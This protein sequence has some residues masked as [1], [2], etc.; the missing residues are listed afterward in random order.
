MPFSG[1]VRL[2]AWLVCVVQLLGAVACGRTGEQPAPAATHVRAENL[3]LIT[4]DTLRWDAVGAYGASAARTPALDALAGRGVRFDRAFAPTPITLPSHASLLTG[5]YPPGHGARHNG[6]AM[7]GDVPTLAVV[8]EKAGFATAAFVSAFP[9]DRRF[10]LS[11]GF[12]TYGDRFPRGAGMRPL[13]ERPGSATV[14]EAIGWLQSRTDPLLSV[15]P[16]LRTARTLRQPARRTA[17]A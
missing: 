15:G 17:G 8:C 6:I 9:L 1:T 5:L 14:D 7:R 4:I 3:L 13:N 11:R 16:P 12:G 2:L 10:G